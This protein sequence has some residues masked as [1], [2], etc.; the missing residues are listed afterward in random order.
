MTATTNEYANM[1]KKTI[2]ESDSPF[3]NLRRNNTGY[4]N[5]RV[6]KI[7]KYLLINLSEY[8]CHGYPGGYYND[9]I[10]IHS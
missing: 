9:A 8:L 1:K 2:V 5:I 3:V 6:T 10:F 7:S 4:P